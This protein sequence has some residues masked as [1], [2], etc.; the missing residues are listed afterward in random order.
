MGSDCLEGAAIGRERGGQGKLFL[1]WRGKTFDLRKQPGAGPEPR[2]DVDEV[3]G[4]HPGG[5]RAGADA[6]AWRRRVG[7]LPW[8]ADGGAAGVSGGADRARTGSG[9]VLPGRA[10][11]GPVCR[12][13]WTGRAAA[14]ALLRHLRGGR[15]DGRRAAAGA[16]RRARVEPGG[17]AGAQVR[18]GGG[19]E[20]VHCGPDDGGRVAAVR[21]P[22]RLTA[23]GAY[24]DR[25][26]AEHQG[27][28]RT[29][30]CG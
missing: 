28:G 26:C 30:R 23:G 8:A 6:P 16:A 25:P 9:R 20:R 2:I 12:G 29:R 3:G 17:L 7:A 4:L 27:R 11:R 13:G 21:A 18:A 15:G 14:T 10:R 19:G 5:R 1:A 22:H 24:L